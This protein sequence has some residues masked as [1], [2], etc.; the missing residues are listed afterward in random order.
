M[1]SASKLYAASYTIKIYKQQSNG[2]EDGGGGG[3]PLRS[4]SIKEK[5]KTSMFGSTRPMQG[6]C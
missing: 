6:F 2:A 1:L 3:V 5:Q 4:S